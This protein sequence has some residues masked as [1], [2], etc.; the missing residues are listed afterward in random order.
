MKYG[1]GFALTKMGLPT[2]DIVD[3]TQGLEAPA[4]TT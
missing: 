2:S 1:T 4:S 3:F